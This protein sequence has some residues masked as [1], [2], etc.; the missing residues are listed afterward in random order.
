MINDSAEAV[1]GILTLTKMDFQGKQ[2]EVLSRY[3]HINPGE[4]ERCLDATPLRTIVKNHEFLTAELNG[5]IVTHLVNAERYLH[6]PQAT[7]DV[8]VLDDKIEIATDVFARQVTLAFSGVTGAVFEDNFFD[9]IPAQKC[10]IRIHH[11]PGADS[12]TVSA[13]NADTVTVALPRK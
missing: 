6:L 12:L 2:P 5:H 1:A 7:L 10:R 9:M 8:K 11:N 13:I 4:A 3:V